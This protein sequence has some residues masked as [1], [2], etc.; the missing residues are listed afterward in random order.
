M[1]ISLRFGSRDDM[2]NVLNAYTEKEVFKKNPFASLDQTGV[3]QL[4]K[5]AIEK[6]RATRPDNKLGL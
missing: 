4:V 3:G 5:I 1:A 2:G 6:G